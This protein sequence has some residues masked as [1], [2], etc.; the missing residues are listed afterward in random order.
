MVMQLKSWSHRWSVLG[1]C[2]SRGFGERER[3]S[4]RQENDDLTKEIEQLRVDR[5][6]DVEELVYLKWINA[7]LRYELRNYQPP[8][9]KTV[10]RDLSKSL[11]HESEEKAKQLILEYANTE[12]TGDKGSHIDFESD[13]WT[14]PTSLLTDS[15]EY[16]DF[17]ADNSSATK[18]HTSSKHKLFNKLRRIIRGKDTHNDHNL[19][20]DNYSAYG[21]SSKSVA[22]YGGNEGQGNIFSSHNS[23]RASLDLPRWKSPKE[24]DSKDTHSVHRHSDVGVFPGYKRFILDGEVS[25]DSPPKDRSDHDSDSAEK[26]ELAKYAEVLKTSRTGTPALKLN[27]HRKSSSAS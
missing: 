12:G 24:H 10:A 11:S 25:S 7:C 19:S 4:L 27:V 22:A 23:S 17:S 5:S 2:E 20:E 9:G 8:T 15:G 3:M 6:S 26:S 16:D 14:S 18:T 1:D 21:S 13:R